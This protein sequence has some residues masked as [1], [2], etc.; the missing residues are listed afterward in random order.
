MVRVA[1]TLVM[2]DR[3]GSWQM[4]LCA[5]SDCIPI[6]AAAGH[7][8]YLKFTHFYVQEMCHLDI[9]H[10]DVFRKFEKGFY[11][12]RRS[13][14]SWTGLSSDLVIEQTLMKSL[15]GTGGLTHGS[16]MSEQQTAIWTMSSPISAEYNIAMQEFSNLSYTTSEQQKDM[17]EA[18]MKKNLGDLEMISTKLA[19]CSPFSTDPSLWNIV[20]GVV[21]AE[22]VTVH[23]YDSVARKVM[24]KMI[25]QAAFIFS[26][27]RKDKTK[28]LGETLAVKVTPD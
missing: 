20:N 2:A 3:I 24:Q 15:K 14:H 5:V 26:F 19:G 6:F 13:S 1:R 22:D 11:V 4:H 17:I 25:G 7:Y 9:K 18:R 12:I 21:A 8:S 10:P 27:S 23:E 16:G 28:T